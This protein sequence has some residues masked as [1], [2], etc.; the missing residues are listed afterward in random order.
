MDGEEVV[1]L[2][3]S[4]I[5]ESD[6][7]RHVDQQNRSGRQGCKRDSAVGGFGFSDLGAGDG[8]KLRD[9]VAPRY[10]AFCYPAAR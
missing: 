9:G 5:A 1:G 2:G 4:D 6:A 8:V 7:G 10:E 3:F